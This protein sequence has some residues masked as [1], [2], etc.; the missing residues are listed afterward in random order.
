MQ[1]GG[2]R[3]IS[4]NQ[5]LKGSMCKIMKLCFTYEPVTTHQRTLNR[6]VKH[7]GLEAILELCGSAEVE[8]GYGESG[9]SIHPEETL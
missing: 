2:G 5:I 4:W 7:L 1:G 3:S 9:Y 6:R 8:P